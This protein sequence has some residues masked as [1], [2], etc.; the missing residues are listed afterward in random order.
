M[1]IIGGTDQKAAYA[2]TFPV[3]VGVDT[4]KTFHQLV[5]RGP[6][7]R[8]GRAVRVDVS[9]DGFERADRYLT[10][11]F[12]A[13]PRERMLVGLEFAGHHGFTFAHFLASRGY[14]VVSVLPFVTKRLKEVEDNSPRKDDAKDAAQVCR[15]VGNGLFVS[16]PLLDDRGAELR[17]LATERRRLSVEATRLKNRLHAALDLAWP[18]LMGQFASLM[19]ETP[20]AFLTRWPVPQDL[21]AAA[22]RAVHALVRTTSRNHIGPERVRALRESACTTIAL[23]EGTAARRAEIQRLLARWQLVR[24]H[25]ADVERSSAE[26][27]VDRFWVLG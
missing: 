18:E 27:C 13:I 3:Q 21:A 20:V 11:T 15:L 4:G 24:R 2:H 16:F 12:P 26:L 5:A 23:A 8:R 9:R 17:L 10:A 19:H 6:D 22:P 25:I 14:A 7:A 1:R